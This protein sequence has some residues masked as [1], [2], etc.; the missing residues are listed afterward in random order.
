MPNAL[1]EATSP[2]LLQHQD[3]PVEWQEWT[4]ATLARARAENKPILLSVGYAA[5]HWC[6]VM[7]HESFEDP[8]IAALMNR[9]FVNIKVDR[10]ERPDLDTVYQQALALMGQQ[11]GWPLTMFLSPEGEPFWGGTYFPP[12]PRYGRPGFPQVLEQVAELWRTGNE[13]IQQN[14]EALAQA[15]RRLAAP[16][17]GTA[18][19][20]LLARQVAGQIA[21]QFD[22]IHGGL[23]GAPK[24]PQAPILRLVW[25]VALRTG[26]RTLRHRVLHTLGRIAQG[27]IYDHLG[28]GFA[29]YAVDAYWLVPHFEKM[30][31][32]NAQLLE[33]LGSAWAATGEPLFEARARETVAWLEREM[34]AEGAFAS[35]LDADSEGEEGRFYVWTAEEIDRLL[36]PDAPAFRLAYGVTAAG[37]WEGRN[38][39]HRL[40]EPGLPDP[41][42]A[43]RLARSRAVL[44][45]AR[46]RRVPPG[47]DDKVLADWNGLMIAALA[48]ASGHFGRPDWLDLARSAFDAVLGHMSEG[49]RLFHSWRAGRRLPMAFLDDYAQMS[50]AALALFEQTGEA[51]YLERAR[52]WVERCRQ[53]FHDPDG[54]CFLS[55]AVADGPLVRPK[56]AHDGPSPA[57]NGTLAVVL[58]SLWH[59][60]GEDR[61]RTAAEGILDA[62]A[63]D[64]ARNLMSH[65]TLL[66][67]ATVLAEPVQIVVAGDDATP[68]F[69]ELLAAAKAAALPA[70]VLARVAPGQ[71]LPADHPAHG[72]G[73]V[74]GRAAA[75]VCVGPTC[76]PP[77]TE[78][79]AL[80]SLLREP[81][82]ANP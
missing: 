29:R 79:A 4:E 8:A 31:Y 28:G 30:L 59:L 12:E 38:V 58:A 55:P 17:A 70:R 11:G 65:A 32:D 81:V 15:L 10:E 63:G 2:Y 77:L 61:Y 34:M 1:A 27:G 62:F 74:D 6:H 78:P 43:E 45:D 51:R 53:D 41:V 72:K 68:G 46:S 26:V 14:R 18:P 36:G 16:E 22:T 13:R 37:N 75:Y 54:G 64:A 3:N 20:P 19:T 50:R 48:Q 76:R 66:L 52:A 67:A 47:R 24:C 33:L 23:A 73:T 25:E 9:H 80:A 42:E 57:A 82:A 5:C 60:T 69:P 40:H 39:L 71:D 7:A 56:N 21:E 35:A 44:L 49:D